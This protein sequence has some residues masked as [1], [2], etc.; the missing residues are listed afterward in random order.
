MFGAVDLWRRH[1]RGTGHS[2]A[3][4]SARGGLFLAAAAVLLIVPAVA[5]GTMLFAGSI[6]LIAGGLVT[7]GTAAPGAG[8]RPGRPYPGLVGLARDVDPRA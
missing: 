6:V 8:R 7:I 5:W 3:A 2:A 1:G 4:G